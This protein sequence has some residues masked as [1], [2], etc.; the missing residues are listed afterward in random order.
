MNKLN[1]L[2]ATGICIAPICFSVYA[3]DKLAPAANMN[4]SY[5][6][7]AK[8]DFQLQKKRL[9]NERDAALTGCYKETGQ[10]Q[11]KCIKQANAD[12]DSKVKREQLVYEQTLHHGASS[13]NSTSGSYAAG[14]VHA[15]KSSDTAS[16]SSGHAR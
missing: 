1:Q 8:E 13:G 15:A 6:K 9:E 14:K 4:E 2:L 16:T 3:A 12:F 5:A 11:S 7:Q 10:A